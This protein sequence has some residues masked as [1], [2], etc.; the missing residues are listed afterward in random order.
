[1]RSDLADGQGEGRQSA[2]ATL[3]DRTSR[4]VRLAHLPADHGAEAVCDVLRTLLVTLPEH[5]R[6][7]L[8]WD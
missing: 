5:A 6:L 2:I 1:V 7:T 3:V 8:T 4:Y